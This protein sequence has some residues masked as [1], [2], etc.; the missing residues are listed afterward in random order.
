[1]SKLYFKRANVYS[2]MAFDYA[3]PVVLLKT[4]SYNMLPSCRTL[5]GKTKIAS[6]TIHS[7]FKNSKV[8]VYK[9]AMHSLWL[10]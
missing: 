6:T 3:C 9:Q 2:N 1:M 4:R 10:L 5:I 8:T 7:R